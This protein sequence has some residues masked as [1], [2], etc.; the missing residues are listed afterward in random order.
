[1]GLMWKDFDAEEHILHIR[2]QM[3]YDKDDKV[4]YLGQHRITGL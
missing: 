1:M 3:L 2:R 4:F